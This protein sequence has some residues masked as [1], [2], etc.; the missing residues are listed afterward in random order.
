MTKENKELIST[1]EQN[2]SVEKQ[3]PASLPWHHK[4]SKYRQMPELN[5]IKE[6]EEGRIKPRNL[7]FEERLAIVAVKR[8]EG[9]TNYQ[10]AKFL[11][12]SSRTIDRYINK[13]KR[14]DTALVKNVTVER[15][16]GNLIRIAEQL[17]QRALRNNNVETA[18]RIECELMDKLQSLGFIYKKPFE[19]EGKVQE[20]VDVN[21]DDKREQE[22]L[23]SRYEAMFGLNGNT[24]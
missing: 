12:C 4:Q 2:Q 3:F 23:I 13:L 15:F 17:R 5:L 6:I 14:R 7:K 22:S 20:K 16:A 11:D 24:N 8:F 10:I 18:W 9:E 19:F 21:V 1:Q